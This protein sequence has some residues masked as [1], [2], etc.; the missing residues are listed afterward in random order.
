L[1]STGP[2]LRRHALDL[3][4]EALG[5]SDVH[6]IR[7]RLKELRAITDLLRSRLPHH[8]REDR[9]AFRNA[10]RALAGARDAE[11][12]LEA[13]DNLGTS[14]FAE[15]RA[16][17][18]CRSTHSVDADAIAALLVAAR[19]RVAAWPV[20][21]MH[22]DDVF[23]AFRRSYRRGRNAMAAATEAETPELFHEWRKRTKALWYESRLLSDDSAKPLHKLSAVLG[24]HHDLAIL[25]HLLRA[26]PETYGDPITVFQLLTLIAVRTRDLQHRAV[27]L[28]EDLFHRR[29]PKRAER[30]GA[31]DEA[32]AAPG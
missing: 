32:S 3:I 12:A 27:S 15:I 6:E 16:V 1:N 11:A 20:E 26:S 13:F 30:R 23:S 22:D 21:G 29:G 25:D 5:T 24:D 9:I 17:L 19:R 31:A 2:L 18:S 8:G 28:G 4:D 14:D 10:A 7:K